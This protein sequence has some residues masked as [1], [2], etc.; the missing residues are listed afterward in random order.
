MERFGKK[1]ITILLSLSMLMTFTPT[2]A[3]A[4]DL[5]SYDVQD[6][7]DEV[8]DPSVDLQEGSETEEPA[9]D[10]QETEE[11]GVTDADPEP[12]ADVTGR[13]TRTGSSRKKS[14]SSD[15]T[16]QR[17]VHGTHII[18]TQIPHLG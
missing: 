8:T 12:T 13:G 3:F 15:H 2:V 6:V 5:G 11:P 18:D 10:L 9:A 17:Q 14:G 1:L 7:T 16:R 4:A